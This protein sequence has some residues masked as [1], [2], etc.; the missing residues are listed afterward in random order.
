MR[1][2]SARAPDLYALGIVAYEALLGRRP[3]T[4]SSVS[5]LA[6]MHC[7]DPVPSVGEG[8]APAWDRFFARALAKDPDDRP[9]TA[10][11]LAATLRVAA[12]IGSAPEDLPRLD[13]G[14]RD[15]WL[16]EAPQNLAEGVAGLDS[17][18]N[19]HQARDAA[20]DLFRGLVRYLVAIALAA[21]AQVRSEH[22]DPA[23]RE[24]L[25]ALRGRELDEDE[26]IKLLRLLVRPFAD[27][28]GAYPVPELVDFVGRGGDGER[29]AIDAMLQLRPSTDHVGSEDVVRSQLVQFI[30]ALAKVMR[31]AAFVLEY[32]LVIPRDHVPERWMGMRRQRRT[33]A[34]VK[35]TD[36]VDD[37]ALLLDRDGRRALVMSPARPG[38]RADRRHRA[39][40]VH[41]RRPRSPRRA[42]DRR[43]RRYG[44]TTPPSRDWFAERVLRGSPARA[45]KR[46]DDRP[47]TSASRRSR[48][49]T[50]I[51]SS[52]ASTRSTPSS[53]ACAGKRY[54]SSSSPSGAGKSSF[55]HAGVM[56]GLPTDW[57]AITMR[58]GMA[59]LTALAARLAAAHVST[60]DLRP[61]LESAPAAAASI[62]AHAAG[63][64]AI[65]IVVDQLEELFTLC[66]N[67]D[68]RDKFAAVL[69]HLSASAE[70]STRVI[71]TVRDDFLMHVESLAPL[72]AALSSAL[73]LIGNPSRDVLIA[74]SSAARRI[75]Y[76]L[77]DGDLA[78]EMVDVVA[79]RPGALALLSFTASRLWELRDRRF[80]QLTRKAYE[81]MGGVAGALGQH[82]ES[83][84][85]SFVADEQ[86]VAREAFRYLVTADMT[87]A[88]LMA[89][90]L[91]QR[92][93]SPRSDAVIAK[94]VDARLLAVVEGET[95]SHIEIIHEAL[96]AA[97]PR[98]QQWTREDSADSRS[99]DE[100]RTAAK[101]WADR[102][103]PR[104][105]LWRGGVLAELTRWRAHVQL[106]ELESAFADASRADAAR[107]TRIRRIIAA[108]AIAIT[109]VFVA[110]L[111]RANSHA[112]QAQSHAED[113]LRESTFDQGRLRML[114][115]D[116]LGALPF[117]AQAYRMGE[118]GAGN[119]L[120]IEEALRP[121]RARLLTL[122]GHTD[123]L[124][125]VI[126][127]PD[128]KLLATASG[129]GTASVWDAETGA[130]IGEIRLNGAALAIAFSSDSKL[131]AVGGR[132]AGVRIWDVV[133]RQVTMTL[134]V[135]GLVTDVAFSP[136]RTQL[137]AAGQGV[138]TSW[139]LADHTPRDLST[140]P[141]GVNIAFRRTGHGSWRGTST[142]R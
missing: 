11:E 35:A 29:D 111:L 32:P 127:S 34:F 62:V 139:R 79:D 13:E 133:Q 69:A 1:R 88:V 16:A 87:R 47:R 20:R 101:Q 58:P 128:G 114:A 71:C 49:P 100:I 51:A 70:G 122:E 137:V 31:A 113:L 59:P 37:Q 126:Y 46:E 5:A 53:I 136:D 125:Q 89:D 4:A 142:A 74:R 102:G 108:V 56:P 21:R 90:E 7:H 107:G 93:A 109:A 52:A 83:T 44:T 123:R 96:I 30:P 28:R 77:S 10:L 138:L 78:A 9:A 95:H 130:M 48:P 132:D 91:R 24:L 43:A 17:A 99:R 129:D 33:I 42:H 18:R 135:D 141:G 82:A 26:R 57:R 64:G 76:E 117:L 72:R 63:T 38:D 55:V 80:K 110:M 68:E 3:F 131:L 104:E 25:R 84:F 116:K 121:T 66:P 97:W 50:P 118:T 41:L 115:G 105:L 75:G 36:L 8:F 39:R 120:M 124:W 14:I 15:A 119:R 85:L 65:V 134:P 67:A 92:L 27:R 61:I 54:S 112:T 81:A 12:G 19:V 40:V 6:S 94:L 45:E 60:A 23:V 2:A 106:T 103:R 73:F 86:R 22:D 140:T 98:L